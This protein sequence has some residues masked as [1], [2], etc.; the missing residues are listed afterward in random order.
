MATMAS[1]P[2]NPTTLSAFSP[3]HRD[4]LLARNPADREAVDASDDPFTQFMAQSPPGGCGSFHS[5]L[6]PGSRSG[7]KNA[8]IDSDF[9]PFDEFEYETT[10]NNNPNSARER[11]EPQETVSS[12]TQ[13]RD[14]NED[15]FSEPVDDE[16][17]QLPSAP[18]LDSIDIYLVPDIDG[19]QALPH[20]HQEQQQQPLPGR[21]PDVPPKPK[22]VDASRFVGTKASAAGDS[23]SYVEATAIMVGDEEPQDETISAAVPANPFDDDDEQD[24]GATSELTHYNNNKGKSPHRIGAATSATAVTA[25]VTNPFED[26]DD[27]QIHHQGGHALVVTTVNTTLSTNPF[28]DDDDGTGRN[29]SADGTNYTLNIAVDIKLPKRPAK[30]KSMTGF[31]ITAASAVAVPTTPSS[32]SSTSSS[33]SSSASASSAVSISAGP[34]VRISAQQIRRFVC[35]GFLPN[36]AKRAL[37]EA[38]GDDTAALKRLYASVRDLVDP[39]SIWRPMLSARVGT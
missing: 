9:N 36:P 5:S 35:I 21:K 34:V 27:D 16:Q 38:N 6:S 10:D 20:G 15:V 4:H 18:P 37:T 14:S 28:A 31:Q 2:V 3:L 11:V 8:D 25:A 12:P 1:P 30:S 13:S 22:R 29:G 32:S 39:S 17:F 7:T 23:V 19:A 24:E 26:E 33:S